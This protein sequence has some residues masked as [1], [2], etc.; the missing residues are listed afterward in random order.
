MHS[1]AS[2]FSLVSPHLSS[3]LTMMCLLRL[4][5]ARRLPCSPFYSQVWARGC[6]YPI[7]T[8]GVHVQFDAAINE[9]SM[10]L[11]LVRNPREET[12]LLN[13]RCD[14]FL[15]CCLVIHKHYTS[16]SLASYIMQLALHWPHVCL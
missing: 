6:I 3:M 1:L 11:K 4:H 7:L 13:C 10:A 12:R 9:Y 5:S 2:K 16:V 8:S 14:A 15:R